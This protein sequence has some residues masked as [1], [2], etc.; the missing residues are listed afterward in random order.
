[1][2][3][4]DIGHKKCR[5][6]LH[7]RLYFRLD[8]KELGCNPHIRNNPTLYYFYTKCNGSILSNL[9]KLMMSK[10]QTL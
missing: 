8:P 1:M 5:H 4:L 6:I 9:D 3:I 2:D 10:N 7:K